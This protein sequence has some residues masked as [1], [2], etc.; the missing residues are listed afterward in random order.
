MSPR[1]LELSDERLYEY[2]RRVGLREHPALA[3]LREATDALPDSSMR[4]SAEQTQLLAFLAELEARLVESQ[5]TVRQ[6]F[7]RL[8]PPEAAGV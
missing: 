1:T 3:A 2:Y 8:C 7:A 5:E 6:I 4:S